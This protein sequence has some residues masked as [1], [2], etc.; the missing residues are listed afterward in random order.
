[1]QQSSIFTVCLVSFASSFETM[2]SVLVAVA[3]NGETNWASKKEAV[4]WG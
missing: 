3:H 4:W 2:S 1:M